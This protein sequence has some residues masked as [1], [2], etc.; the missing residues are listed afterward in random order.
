MVALGRGEANR[1]SVFERRLGINPQTL[2]CHLGVLADWGWIERNPGYGHPL[3]PDYLL[4]APGRKVARAAVPCW[5]V[6]ESLSMESLVRAKWTLPVLTD[7]AFQPKGFA[8]L[9][10]ELEVTPRALSESL[11][12]LKASALVE[13]TARH[14]IKTD[15]QR[16]LL[17]LDPF[18]LS[19]L[20]APL[21]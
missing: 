2:D 14:E 19:P 18:K 21:A 13:S 9:R 1:F 15:E 11:K 7:L 8:Q 12:V 6:V 3:R 10:R 16:R 5:Q 17:R 4:T 20:A